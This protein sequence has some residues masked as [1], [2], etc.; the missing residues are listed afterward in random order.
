MRSILFAVSLAVLSGPAIAADCTQ[1]QL[2]QKTQEI[3]TL[4]QELAKDPANIAA[5]QQKMIPLMQEAQDLQAEAMKDPTN[6]ALIQKSC[7]LLDKQLGIIK[8]E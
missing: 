1:E 3:A 4:T 7:D 5:L 6:P 8:G 2:M